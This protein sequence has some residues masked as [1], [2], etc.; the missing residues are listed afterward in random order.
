MA[1]M[2]ESYKARIAKMKEDH[3]AELA[4]MRRQSDDAQSKLEASEQKSSL[5]NEEW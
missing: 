3:E 1:K 2:E 5:V 4:D